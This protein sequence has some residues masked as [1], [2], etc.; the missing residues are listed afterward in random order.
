MKISFD[1]K[2]KNALLSKLEKSDKDAFRL[3]IK[4]FG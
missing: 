4:G 2:T 1:E 3:M